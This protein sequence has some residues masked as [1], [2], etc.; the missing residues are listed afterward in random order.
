MA[1]MT[2]AM[3]TTVI[4]AMSKYGGGDGVCERSIVRSVVWAAVTLIV[5]FLVSYPDLAR[6]NCA[7]WSL[8]RD[9]DFVH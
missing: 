7:S 2:I 1:V 9:V 8:A 4:M 5:A 6:A 3:I